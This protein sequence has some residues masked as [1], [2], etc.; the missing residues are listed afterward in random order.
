MSQGVVDYNAQVALA[1]AN[2][3]VRPGM[4][5]TANIVTQADQD[6]IIV[7]NAAITTQGGSSYILEPASPVADAVIA[8]SSAGGIVLGKL[9]SSCR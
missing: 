3:Q 6:V 2:D 7:P 1:Q 4:S 8:S 9:R 5:V